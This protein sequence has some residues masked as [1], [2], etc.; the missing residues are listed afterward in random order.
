VNGGIGKAQMPKTRL[1]CPAI[2]TPQYGC[3][4]ATLECPVLG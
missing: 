1:A 4:R 3:P 2:T